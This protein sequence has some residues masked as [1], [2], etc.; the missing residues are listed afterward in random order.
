MEVDF[1]GDPPPPKEEGK[2]KEEGRPETF[3]TKK[4][5]QDA[6][7]FAIDEGAKLVAGGTGRPEGFN[8][9]YFVRPTVF[10]DVNNDMAIAREEIF[11]P[12]LTM[13]PFETEA[14]A[15]EIANDTQ[16]G[17]AAYVQS[18]D[19]ARAQKV[20]RELRAGMVLLNGAQRP[21]G[22]PF[23][24]YKMSG[25]GREGGDWGLEDFLEVKAISGWDESVA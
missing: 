19:Q 24:G 9:G 7:L 8:R 3:R 16:Y 25:N 21:G 23:G 5:A 4:E 6:I 15:I 18:G 22:S 2:P 13:I 1:A 20:A 14:E 17:L 10:A 11:G 12:V